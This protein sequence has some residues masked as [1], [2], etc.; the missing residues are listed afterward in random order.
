MYACVSHTDT[1]GA[2]L[3]AAGADISATDQYG[4]DNTEGL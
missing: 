4:C 2:S 1:A 3:I